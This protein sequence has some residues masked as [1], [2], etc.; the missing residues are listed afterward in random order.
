[1]TIDLKGGYVV[2]ADTPLSKELAE[3]GVARISYY[4]GPYRQ[5]LA[6]LQEAG[7]KA[8]SWK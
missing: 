1:V 2:M 8:L 5:V 6:M 7:R 3:L 4:P